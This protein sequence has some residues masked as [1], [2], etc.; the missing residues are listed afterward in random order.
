MDKVQIR[1]L[2][3]RLKAE[4]AAQQAQMKSELETLLYGAS[5]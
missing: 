3:Q 2:K 5:D 4:Y 1:F